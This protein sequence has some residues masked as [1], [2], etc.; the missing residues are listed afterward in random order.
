MPIPFIYYDNY[1]VPMMQDFSHLNEVPMLRSLYPD[2]TDEELLL[3]WHNLEGYM[4]V[5]MKIE[6]RIA[7]EKNIDVTK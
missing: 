3:A 5:I 7:S 2:M 4:R 6:N 1:P